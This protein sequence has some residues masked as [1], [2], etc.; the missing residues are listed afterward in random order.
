MKSRYSDRIE[1][2]KKKLE[3]RT[4]KAIRLGC[5]RNSDGMEFRW[6]FLLH[7]FQTS[8]GI[9]LIFC[10][11][12]QNSVVFHVRNS[13]F[14]RVIHISPLVHVRAHVHFNVYLR[15]HFYFHVYVQA[16]VLVYV[17]MSKSISM[18]LCHVNVHEIP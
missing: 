11:I 4:N 2:R 12:P 3:S 10:G 18:F 16:R 17:S 8:V 6:N 14:P 1:Q 7:Y 5:P 9:G 13:E 15:V